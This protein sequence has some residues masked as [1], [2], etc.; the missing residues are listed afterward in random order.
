[1]RR[2]L[3]KAVSSD[4][5]ILGSATVYVRGYGPKFEKSLLF[6]SHK[7]K[8]KKKLNKTRT[9]DNKGENNKG[10]SFIILTVQSL[11]IIHL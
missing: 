3:L 9:N 4:H 6:P 8:K 1:M 11:F 5:S 10:F 2:A 7:K